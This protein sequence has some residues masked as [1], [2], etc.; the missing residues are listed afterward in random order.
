M[1]CFKE[2]VALGAWQLLLLCELEPGGRTKRGGG[3]SALPWAACPSVTWCRTGK[4]EQL[5][6]PPPWPKLK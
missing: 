5:W 4:A 2:V 6:L 3:R 1:L